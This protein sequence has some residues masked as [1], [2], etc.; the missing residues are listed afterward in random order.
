MLQGRLAGDALDVIAERLHLSAKTVSNHQTRIRQKQGV[1]SG[2][3]LLRYA[4]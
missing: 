2:E 3:E 4:Q 1:G